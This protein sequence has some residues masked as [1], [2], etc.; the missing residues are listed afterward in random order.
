MSDLYDDGEPDVVAHGEADVMARP[1]GEPQHAQHGHQAAAPHM[2]AVHTL[3]QGQD[4]SGGHQGIHFTEAL[5]AAN[6]I[7][8]LL[9]R[10]YDR[11]EAKILST[12]PATA[13]ATLNP[14][15]AA[16]AA[17][18]AGQVLVTQA[19]PAGA[20]TV[21]WTVMLRGTLAANDANNFGL[22][23][24]ATLLATSVNALNV[25]SVYP[26]LAQTVIVPAGGGTL[27][28]QAIAGATAG[29]VYQAG[30][31]IQPASTGPGPLILAQSKE[32]AE[33]AAG[34]GAAFA[35]PAGGYLPAGVE[36][37]LRN[38]DEVWAAWLGTAVLVSVSVSRR[39][40]VPDQP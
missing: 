5:S 21:N 3:P 9:P 20:Y 4:L 39:L 33:Y 16:A 23:L 28:I 34:Q 26:Q 12:G 30:M 32:I 6:P 31:T 17:P 27:T 1:H 24:G 22:Y 37:T 19:L 8:Q 2:S 25:G 13:Q 7:A 18:T 14:A 38:C 10:D 40:P 29:S 15:P 11:I 35:G 36:R